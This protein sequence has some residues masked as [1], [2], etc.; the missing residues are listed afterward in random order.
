M[1]NIEVT[2]YGQLVVYERNEDD[3]GMTPITISV[4]GYKKRVPGEDFP[5]AGVHAVYY[6]D[7][8]G[9]IVREAYYSSVDIGIRENPFVRKV[10]KNYCQMKGSFDDYIVG[11]FEEIGDVLFGAEG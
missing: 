11:E 6:N 7:R 10:I 2:N 9:E 8:L 5:R 1:D 3:E 4:V